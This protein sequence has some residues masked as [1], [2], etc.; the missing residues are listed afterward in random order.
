MSCC[1]CLLA[2]YYVLLINIKSGGGKHDF[3]YMQKETNGLDHISTTHMSSRINN[4]SNK[5]S[6]LRDCPKKMVNEQQE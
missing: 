5:C 1:Y 4:N 2:S 6:E 3:V